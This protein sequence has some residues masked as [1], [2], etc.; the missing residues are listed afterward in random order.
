MTG[1]L[2]PGYSRRTAR[3]RRRFPF[4]VSEVPPF[5]DGGDVLGDVVDRVRPAVNQEDHGG[6]AE[7]KHGFDEVVLVSEQVEAA[8]VAE[9]IFPGFAA[10][11]FVAAQCEYD[12]VGFFGDTHR[13]LDALRVESGIAELS[14][15]S[16]VGMVS[17]IRRASR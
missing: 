15:S 4:P 12:E 17:E 2:P 13:F 1:S 6:L 11:L 9:V 5:E 14:L 8:A 7:R 16:N 3:R 10:R